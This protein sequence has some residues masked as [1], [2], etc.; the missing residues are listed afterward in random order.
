M[1]TKITKASRDV[2]S[3]VA[4]IVLENPDYFIDNFPQCSNKKELLAELEKSHEPWH[5]YVTERPTAFFTLRLSGT[6][7]VFDK[8][9]SGTLFSSDRLT[10]DL[11]R[12]LERMK[13]KSLTLRASEGV[14][15]SLVR[16]G[17]EKRRLLI[18]LSGQVVETKLMPILPLSNPFEKGIPV[19]AKLMHDSY[20]KSS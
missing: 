6:N 18:N 8:F 3:Q 11:R 16:S 12:D 7:A 4:D 19:L 2:R 13:I 1:I 5:V 9:I 15:E 10:A 20:E 14:A 17:F